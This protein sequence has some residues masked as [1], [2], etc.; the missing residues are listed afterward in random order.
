MSA[1][2][3]YTSEG[4]LGE[5]GIFDGAQLTC[6]VQESPA[7][8][9]FSLASAYASIVSKNAIDKHSSERDEA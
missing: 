4:S 9:C 5:N 1:P 6:V 2:A 8:V 7:D 3:P